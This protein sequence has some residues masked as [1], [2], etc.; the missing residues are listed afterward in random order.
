M[1]MNPIHFFTLGYYPE[2]LFIGD[3]ALLLDFTHI[4][5]LNII[6]KFTIKINGFV[7]I[8]IFIEFELIY[9]YCKLYF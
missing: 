8:L 1:I 9:K 2:Y 6:R 3:G 4:L 5:E 7:E